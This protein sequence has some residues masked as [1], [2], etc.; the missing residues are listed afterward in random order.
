MTW[1]A[2]SDGL[3]ATLVEWEGQTTITLSW[4]AVPH[5]AGCGLMED[6]AGAHVYRSEP[7][8]L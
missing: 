4:S 1:D 7:G 3:V 2:F 8:T 6:T 5:V